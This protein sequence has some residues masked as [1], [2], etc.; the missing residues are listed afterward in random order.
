MVD[1][2]DKYKGKYG[3]YSSC[4]QYTNF[5]LFPA[6]DEAAAAYQCKEWFSILRL[7][8]PQLAQRREIGRQI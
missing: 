6:E 3:Q 1:E 2:A 4:L 5:F 8:S 7:Q